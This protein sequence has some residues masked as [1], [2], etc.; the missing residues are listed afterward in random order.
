MVIK[1]KSKNIKV[2]SSQDMA[3][4][5]QDILKAE[6]EIDRDKEHF[7]VI[8]LTTKSHIKYI[9]LVSL[10]VLNASLVHP[11]EVFR[12][13]I[14]QAVAGIIVGH[15]HPGGDPEPSDNDVHVT[16]TLKEAGKIIGIPVIDHIIITDD[17]FISLNRRGYL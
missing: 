1:I 3:T 17:S 2:T 8:G 6:N 10:G 11:R 13:A 5:L 7:W 9:E 14:I 16:D 15:N 12:Y 4:I